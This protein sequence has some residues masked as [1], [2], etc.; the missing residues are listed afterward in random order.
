MRYALLP[1]ALGAALLLA[2]SGCRHDQS[3]APT[4][5]PCGIASVEETVP[6]F[7]LTTVK[8]ETLRLSE[9]R[10]K[11]VLLDFWAILCAG[12]VEGLDRYR[13]D[14]AFSANPHLQIIAIAQETSA[15]ATRKF[16]EEHRWPFPVVLLTP[17]LREA[18]LG[19]GPVALPQ[20]RLLDREGR[21]RYRLGFESLQPETVKCLVQALTDSTAAG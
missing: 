5:A 3:S 14:P 7:T 4:A 8:G 17:E 6:D 12:C 16:A 15:E 1:P 9:M 21:L 13:D 11:V 18:F 19:Q 20:I 2:M 10:G